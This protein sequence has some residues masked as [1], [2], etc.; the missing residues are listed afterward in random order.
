MF[1]R[2]PLTDKA[3]PFHH[4]PGLSVNG[5]V[6]IKR[7]DQFGLAI[8]D[9]GTSARKVEF[10]LPQIA[11]AD[12]T[13][14]VITDR[15]GSPFMLHLASQ[16][17]LVGLNVHCF[18]VTPYQDEYRWFMSALQIMGANVYGNVP[19]EQAD[20]MVGVL[21]RQGKR[22]YIANASGALSP[23]YMGGVALFDELLVD[24]FNHQINDARVFVGINSGVTLAGMMLAK[25]L[26]EHEGPSLERRRAANITLV[27][28]PE[29]GES[30]QRAKDVLTHYAHLL[31]LACTLLMR[32]WRSLQ[33]HLRFKNQEK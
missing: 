5:P 15:Y 32:V 4:C 9:C 7:E 14:V 25:E 3:S 23:A 22:V 13:D 2:Y 16:L 30:E 28:V 17:T 26:Y 6:Y 19:F 33:I 8:G 27:G 1:K 12:V 21:V 29:Y 20:E 31:Q 11:D 10:M 18:M 24:C